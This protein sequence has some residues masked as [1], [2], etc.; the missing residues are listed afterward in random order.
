MNISIK[1]LF[2]LNNPIIVDIRNKYYY[3]MG[4]IDNAISIPYYNLLN[5]YSYYLDKNNSY[6]VYC[7]T[8][9]QS[10]EIVDRLSKFGYKVF[11]IDGG[12]LEY[13]RLKKELRSDG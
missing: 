6:Y 5:N 4:H 10:Y 11:N 12:Y 3:D 13:C 2:N 9:E 1:D 8:G 7:D